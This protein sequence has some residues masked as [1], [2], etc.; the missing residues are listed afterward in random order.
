MFGF[1]GRKRGFEFISE[2]NR[3]VSKAAFI[4]T[5]ADNKSAGYDFYAPYAVELAPL[6][7]Q[8]IWTNVKA[9]MKAREVLKIYMRSSVGISGIWLMNQVGVI[10]SSYYN[11][12]KNEG[13]IGICLYNSTNEPMR[14]EAGERIAQGIFEKYLIA[15]R[16]KPLKD[17]RS[18]G[19]GSSN[20]KVDMNTLPLLKGEE[21]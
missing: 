3:K 8:I 15:D 19:Y 10:D 6:T 14:V 17:S 21:L 2:G 4:P 20:K 16:D 9:Y 13:N 5:R 7:S 11:N 12:P 18:G 1:F